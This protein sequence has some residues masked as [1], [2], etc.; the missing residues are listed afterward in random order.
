MHFILD[1]TNCSWPYMF[2]F[3]NRCFHYKPFRMFSLFF[4]YQ[5]IKTLLFSRK[6][7]TILYR[8][9]FDQEVLRIKEFNELYIDEYYVFIY[10]TYK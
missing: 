10:N 5:H 7:K 4:R 1:C 2:H 6:F 9:D 8:F 3:P